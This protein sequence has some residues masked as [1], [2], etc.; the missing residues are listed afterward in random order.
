MS[1]EAEPLGQPCPVVVH[2]DPELPGVTR[3]LNQHSAG[4][5]RARPVDQAVLE[6][7]LQQFGQHQGERRG[8]RARKQA[9]PPGDH[10]ADPRFRCRDHAGH[11]GH[12]LGDV[13]EVDELFRGVRQRLVDDRDRSDPADRLL[14]RVPGFRRTGAAG[15]EPQQRGHGLQVVLHPVV[16]L[17]D[18]GVLGHQLTLAV[19][20]LG[21][22]ADQHQ[23]TGP[24]VVHDQREGPELNHRAVALDLGLA[25]GPPL[26]VTMSESSAGR[27]DEQSWSSAA[28]VRHPPGRRSGRAC[29]RRTERSGWRT[30]P[31]RTGR[32]GAGRHRPGAT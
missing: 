22:V 21:D 9:E 28:P 17:A 1:V 20:Q 15:L 4:P 27:P 11:R 26:A 13:V 5:R 29:D 25:G 6:G 23:G 12:P 19:P 30:R 3:R 10:R 8:N 2:A 32:A 16:D 14:Q 7:V 24:H 18:R 31:A